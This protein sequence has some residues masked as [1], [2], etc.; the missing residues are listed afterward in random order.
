MVD[1]IIWFFIKSQNSLL[2]ILFFVSDR[3]LRL[4]LMWT[5]NKQ[6]VWGSK[7]VSTELLFISVF[8]YEKTG[9]WLLYYGP[10]HFIW[11]MVNINLCM[12]RMLLGTTN[13]TCILKTGK[14][15]GISDDVSTSYYWF[16]SFSILRSF[17]MEY[18]LFKYQ[19]KT[20]ASGGNCLF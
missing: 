16:R 14:E 20:P 10:F 1:V 12:F 13:P 4:S 9:V 5:R 15:M 6:P 18:T 19:M 3:K 17:K 8:Y 11:G 7:Y 2:I